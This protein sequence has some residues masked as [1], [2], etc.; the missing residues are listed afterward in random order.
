LPKPYKLRRFYTPEEIALHQTADDCWVS[1]FS[2]VYD[3]SKLLADNQAT[4]GDLCVPI[5]K[6]A[7]TDISHWFDPMTQ[8]VSS[9][10]QINVSVAKES[11]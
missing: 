3:L 9:R 10:Q 4:Q 8:E 2:G 6:V 5:A 11:N 1:F 7:G